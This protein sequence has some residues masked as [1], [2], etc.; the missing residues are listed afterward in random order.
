MDLKELRETI[1]KIAEMAARHLDR[2]DLDMDLTVAMNQEQRDDLAAM[3][4]F[5]LND[6]DITPDA[7][8]FN[9]LH[10]LHGLRAVYQGHPGANCFLPRSFGYASRLKEVSNA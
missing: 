7:I 10:D 8:I 2:L 4:D 1:L 9:I 3:I 6:A 5:L